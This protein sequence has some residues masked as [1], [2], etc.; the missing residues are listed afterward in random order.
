MSRS[1]GYCSVWSTR[2]RRSWWDLPKAQ[3]CRGS[4][5]E[6]PWTKLCAFWW[7]Y[8]LSKLS[9][10]WI[11]QMLSMRK[12]AWLLVA[13]SCKH[14]WSTRHGSQHVPSS[15]YLRILQPLVAS[16]SWHRTYHTKWTVQIQ[17]GNKCT[18][19]NS[20]CNESQLCSLNFQNKSILLD[21]NSSLWSAYHTWQIS[22]SPVSPCPLHLHHG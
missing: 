7:R 21:R 18:N 1:S 15:I 2:D 5:M 3:L 19:H 20:S 22:F 14:G 16:R 6:N 9:M 4:R 12:L 8:L 10:L 11:L 13:V 17:Q